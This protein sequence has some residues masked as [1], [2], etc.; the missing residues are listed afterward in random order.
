MEVGAQTKLARV[1]EE[2]LETSELDFD[3]VWELEL[4]VTDF[5]LVFVVVYKL[6][7]EEDDLELVLLVVC[8][9]DVE[10]DTSSVEVLEDVCTI[11]VVVW[12]VDVLVITEW[13]LDDSELLDDGT[14]C[15]P[16]PSRQWSS[17][18]F[19]STQWYWFSSCL[20]ALVWD[21]TT[22]LFQN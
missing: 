9:L 17:H 5:V 22:S 19:P 8:E 13:V 3:E 15:R 20:R 4:E 2:A 18:T 11:V 10:D 6:E 7:V 12:T 16:C 14:G 1:D 21:A